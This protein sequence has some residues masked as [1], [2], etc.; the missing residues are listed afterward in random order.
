MQIPFT[1]IPFIILG[2]LAYQC[3][4]GKDKNIK[5]KEI[6]KKK[7]DDAI[8]TEHHYSKQRKLAQD[9]KK[10]DCPVIF[11]IK[12]IFSFPA[13][14]IEND[15]RFNRDKATKQL[16]E[17]FSKLL[18]GSSSGESNHHSQFIVRFPTGG[19]RF[20]N[21]GIAAGIIEPLDDRIS[22]FLKKIIRGGCRRVKELESRALDFVKEELFHGESNPSVYR[23]RFY[24]ERKKIR[25]LITFVKVESRYSKIDQENVALL[26][27]NC[28]N[29]DIRFIPRF[30]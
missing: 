25:N 16:K 18:N 10:K 8:C 19:H 22:S 28:N 30:V 2:K 20:H 11:N 12:K 23:S 1:G 26:A 4:Q 21:T 15:T 14:R 9:T 5:R 24:P 27:S 17:S 6:F 7:R 29:A 13:F 3:H